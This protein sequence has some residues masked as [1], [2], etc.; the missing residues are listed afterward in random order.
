MTNGPNL[1]EPSLPSTQAKGIDSVDRG[2]EVVEII[3]LLI[4]W[5][6]PQQYRCHRLLA[7][8]FHS[9][10]RTHKERYAGFKTPLREARWIRQICLLGRRFTSFAVSSWSAQLTPALIGHLIV[11]IPEQRLNGFGMPLPRARLIRQIWLFGE[12]FTC[13][14]ALSCSAE[15]AEFP[16]SLIDPELTDIILPTGATKLFLQSH[17]LQTP[18]N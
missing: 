17:L 12:R 9:G 13:F 3:P 16:T 5:N 15:S 1:H 11:K 8:I 6:R 14:E 7:M 4:P 18:L 2:K 10:V